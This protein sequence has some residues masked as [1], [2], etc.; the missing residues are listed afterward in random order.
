VALV[1]ATMAVL[2][3]CG[4]QGPDVPDDAIHLKAGEP[5]EVDGLTLTAANFGEDTVSLIASD[6]KDFDDAV[7]L[8]VGKTGVV[9]GRTFELVDV[10]VDGKGDDVVE[11]SGQAWVVE[12]D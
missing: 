11:D 2:A 1:V 7:D 10:E 9:K 5:L 3:A 12:V 8:A 4:A 6:G